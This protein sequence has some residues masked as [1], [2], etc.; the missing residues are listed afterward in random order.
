MSSPFLRKVQESRL[1]RSI[2]WTAGII[3]LVFCIPYLGRF[4]K[5]LWNIVLTGVNIIFGMVEYLLMW[6]GFQPQK[7]MRI[8]A[9]I[10]KDTAS[11]YLAAAED[12]AA[13]LQQAAQIFMTANIRL[14]PA[15]SVNA[16][17]TTHNSLPPDLNA[18]ITHYPIPL[19]SNMLDVDC[20]APALQEDLGLK[21]AKFQ[22]ISRTHLSHTN[23][24]RLTG[25]GSPVIIFIVRSFKQ[26]H[27]GCSLGPL[28]DYVTVR[29]DRLQ[30]IAHEIGH[31]CNLPHRKERDN[32][33][34]SQSCSPTNLSRWQIAL[35][36]ASRH[37][38]FF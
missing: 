1:S 7:Q 31:A 26:N 5:W 27:G 20:N 30:C 21:G 8:E 35:I 16:S 15:R 11:N 28:T 25:Y 12:V 13:A 22:H 6:V 34:F 17:S 36:R 18:C 23:L 10:L 33:M 29:F 14:I 37:V 3:E 19:D 38:S 2:N 24:R 32:L 9:V 4:L